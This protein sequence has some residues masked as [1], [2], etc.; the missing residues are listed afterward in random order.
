M[1]AV[2]SSAIAGL[3]HDRFFL[4]LAALLAD[5]VLPTMPA[6][7]RL[8]PSPVR[9]ARAFG[10]WLTHR[11]DRKR[12]SEATRLVRGLAAALL[13]LAAV[14]AA[15]VAIEYAAARSYAGAAIEFLI[16]LTILGQRALVVQVRGV[17]RA[18][19]RGPGGLDAARK[20]L[21]AL[22]EPGWDVLAVDRHGVARIAIEGL[23]TGLAERVVAP[24]FWYLLLGLPGLLGAVAI[25]GIAVRGSSE[26]R[27]GFAAL[28]LDDLIQFPPARLA[29][30]ICVLAACI[31]PMGR[32]AAALRT[33]AKD[34]RKHPSLNRGWPI[35]AFAGALDLSLAGPRRRADGVGA[36]APWI[37][38]GRAR[39]ECGDVYHALYLFGAACLIDFVLIAALAL[40]RY[41]AGAG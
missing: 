12:R 28:R 18:L 20:S 4:I 1:W 16:V 5:A 15:G 22:I 35:A 14:A 6:V 7:G 32:P 30:A 34:A 31:A 21:L 39:A 41:A 33:M 3:A 23:A 25:N 11:L 9:S 40:A 27:F 29:G 26:T 8:F 19:A 24:V 37:G 17:A 10:I 38:S 13:T 2:L 36:P